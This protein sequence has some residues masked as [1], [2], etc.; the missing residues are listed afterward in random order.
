MYDKLGWVLQYHHN[1]FH[2]DMVEK[3]IMDDN[4]SL[5]DFIKGYEAVCISERDTDD[6]EFTPNEFK[7]V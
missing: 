2:A 7:N 4:V 3:A 1:V 6:D 5:D